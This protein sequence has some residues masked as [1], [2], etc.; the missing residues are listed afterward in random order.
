VKL[1]KALLALMHCLARLD[2]VAKTIS[3]DSHP[4]IAEQAVS[5]IVI[6]KPNVDHMR[7]QALQTARSMFAAGELLHTM[8]EIVTNHLP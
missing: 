1:N 5:I 8:R 6:A 7:L 3:A 4:N 2:A